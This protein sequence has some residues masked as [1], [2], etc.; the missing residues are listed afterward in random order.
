MSE[1][2]PDSRIF[3]LDRHFRVYRRNRRQVIPLIA[4]PEA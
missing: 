4:P 1:L 2:R 3:T